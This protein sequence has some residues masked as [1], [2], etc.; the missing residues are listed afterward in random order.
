MRA[1]V[2]VCIY[3]ISSLQMYFKG[4]DVGRRARLGTEL[5]PGEKVIVK[6]N[7]ALLLFAFI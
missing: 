3:I 5:P 1:C 6:G 7:A 4:V 2:C